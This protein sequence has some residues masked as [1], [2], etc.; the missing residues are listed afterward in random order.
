[1][2][3]G[4]TAEAHRLADLI[5]E[6]HDLAVLTQAIT[7]VPRDTTPVPNRGQVRSAIRERREQLQRQ[8]SVLG[9]RLYAEKPRPMRRRMRAYMRAERREQA[10]STAEQMSASAA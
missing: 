8:A 6:D 5:G 10:L 7:N 3:D 9:W 4:W 2:T 1:M